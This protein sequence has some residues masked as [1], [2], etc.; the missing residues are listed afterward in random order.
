MLMLMDTFCVQGI[1][2]HLEYMYNRLFFSIPRTAN[3]FALKLS[4]D[5][6]YC[7]LK[8]PIIPSL[9]GM[10]IVS[11]INICMCEKPTSS[12]RAGPISSGISYLSAV[13]MH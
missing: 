4:L 11:L 6:H 5:M 9:L 2:I 10:R 3:R 1:H 13:V 12:S 8:K 7:F